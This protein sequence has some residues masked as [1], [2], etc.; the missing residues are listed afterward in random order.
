MT[1]ATAAGPALPIDPRI[2]ARRIAVR[3]DEGRRRLRRL[4]TLGGL[5]GALAFAGLTTRTPLLDV[6]RIHVEGAQRT[7]VEAVLA[8]TGI[9][10]GDPLTDVDL[11]RARAALVTLP[12]VADAEVTRS[13]SGTI[14]VRLTERVAVATVA[15]G[16]RGW[17]LLD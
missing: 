4:L 17:A 16:E 13:W 3:R 7:A 10:R 8:T 12:W 1:D 5:V 15:A 14:R 6:D 9:R 2:R 11:E